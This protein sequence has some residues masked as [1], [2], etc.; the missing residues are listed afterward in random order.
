MCYIN[1]QLTYLLTWLTWAELEVWDMFSRMNTANIDVS[2]IVQVHSGHVVHELSRCTV[3]VHCTPGQCVA[4]ELTE[5]YQHQTL[6]STY[7]IGS[8]YAPNGNSS[9][10]VTPTSPAKFSTS[11]HTTTRH[12]SSVQHCISTT[13][14]QNIQTSSTTA[15]GG[16][17][18]DF[19]SR[20]PKLN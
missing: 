1:P 13:S 8:L 2:H 18:V 15:V 16:H 14:A 6:C 5:K 12:H 9:N 17:H 7:I 10:L 19:S 3:N 20:R 11:K 4:E